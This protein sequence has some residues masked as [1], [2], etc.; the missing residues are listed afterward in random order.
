MMEPFESGFNYGIQFAYL[1]QGDYIEQPEVFKF[2][3]EDP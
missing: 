3:V 1:L 2:R